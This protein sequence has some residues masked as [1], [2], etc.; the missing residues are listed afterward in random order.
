MRGR[1]AA[2]ER[3]DFGADIKGHTK[4][5]HRSPAAFPKERKNT[6]DEGSLIFHILPA[7]SGGMAAIKKTNLCQAYGLVVKMV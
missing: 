3:K 5:H 4:L 7:L 1:D 2:K 6:A